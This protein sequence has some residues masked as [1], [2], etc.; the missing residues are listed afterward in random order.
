MYDVAETI[1]PGIDLLEPNIFLDPFPTYAT[2]RQNHPVCQ[3]EPKGTWAISRYDDVLFALKRH[4]LFSSSAYRALNEPDWIRDECKRD[5]FLLTEDPPI[6]TKRR[7]LI[8]KAFVTSVIDELVP[9][10]RKT[11]HHL[12]GNIFQQKGNIEFVKDFSYPYVSKIIARLTGI[13]EQQSLEEFSRWIE[14]TG[15]NSIVK[16]SDDVIKELESVIIRQNDYFISI[17]QDRQ[18]NPRDDFITALVHSE[19]DGSKLSTRNLCNVIDLVI[20]SGFHTTINLLSMSMIHLSQRPALVSRLR[21]S[22]ALIA[23][24]IEEVLRFRSPAPC[25]LRQTKQAVTLHDVTIP[26]DQL[27]MILLAAANHD[28]DHFPN[29][30]QFDIDREE[31]KNHLAFGQGAHAC[32]G[33]ALAR[34]EVKIVLESLLENFSHF[35]CPKQSELTWFKTIMTNGVQSLPVNFQ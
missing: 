27:V 24:F 22:P 32:I 15:E 28:P 12:I 19:I 9:L 6:H 26:G 29:P 8:N 33:L 25:L 13:D 4:D 1:R 5:M 11:A 17:I 10:M 35:S 18:K 7:A 2:L 31:N 20:G 23:N 21:E 34:Q 14:L 3:L 16:P 30:D